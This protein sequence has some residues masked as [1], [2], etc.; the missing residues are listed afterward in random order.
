MLNLPRKPSII[1]SVHS[2]RVHLGVPDFAI[3]GER[4]KHFSQMAGH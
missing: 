3:L 1:L 2:E 4:F